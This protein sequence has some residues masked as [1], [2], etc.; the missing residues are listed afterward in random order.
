MYNASIGSA[1]P[2]AP[3]IRMG[4]VDALAQKAFP[5]ALKKGIG[6][7]P[8]FLG[9]SAAG[10]VENVGG[11]VADRVWA[12]AHNA[13]VTN[14]G[15]L[16]HADPATLHAISN[17]AEAW[18]KRTAAYQMK[19]QGLSGAGMMTVVDPLKAGTRVFEKPSLLGGTVLGGTGK[20]VTDFLHAVGG[21]PQTAVW[22]SNIGRVG[23][24]GGPAMTDLTSTIRNMSGDPGRSGAFRNATK[25]A[26]FTNASPWG[27]IYLQST[28]R[29]LGIKKG[30]WP[31]VIMKLGSGV[32]I[33]AAMVT[34]Y[35]ADLG[36]EYLKHQLF[37]RSTDNILRNV[38]I[39]KK[40]KLPTEGHEIAFFDPLTQLV[41]V[42]AEA[43]TASHLGLWT[44]DYWKG[45]NA[46]M[47]N[48]YSEM[49]KQR[50][51]DFN[52][53]GDG[54][55]GTWI[56]QSAMP[57]LPPAI[58]APLAVAGIQMRSPVDMHIAPENR[59][60]GYMAG[61]RGDPMEQNI[62]GGVLPGYTG[63]VASAIGAT[64]GR[65]LHDVVVQILGD[66]DPMQA[67][68][69]NTVY[70]PGQA[71]DR[72]VDTIGQKWADNAPGAGAMFHTFRSITPSQTAQSQ[73]VKLKM[74]GV[75]AI[76]KAVSATEDK[77]FGDKDLLG[78]RKSGYESY[79][80][81]HPAWA[82]DDNTRMLGE[83]IARFKK[84]LAP[85]EQE[86]GVAYQQRASLMQSN[87]YTP[88]QKRDQLEQQTYR[89]INLHE[90][91]SQDIM[92]QEQV[93]SQRYGVEVQFDKIKP[94]Q[95]ML[96][97]KPRINMP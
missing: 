90:R 14:K 61:N 52:P 85:T 32:M 75:D 92:R 25:A 83:D 16:S 11:V 40:G 54:M 31:G 77:K 78:S 3:G 27:N 58:A 66:V 87:K 19:Q 45:E 17:F 30:D 82:P 57:V 65:F 13:L 84:G 29:V 12:A 60:V 47:A 63:D 28:G 51:T 48:A 86:I 68:R 34:L 74:D 69:G 95:P 23:T 46:A 96:G 91:I 71:L 6:F 10:A 80:G 88:Y 67:Q 15:L 79:A 7:D 50:Y 9:Q 49:F 36:E 24:P 94:G 89:I 59:R 64:F 97:F 55:F 70:S 21:G 73:F 72:A 18:Y 38:Y 93:M 33:P 41:K 26:E 35:N 39:G 8:T 4:M 20:I 53:I 81:A 62:L 37:G 76:A 2:R 43:I 56:K 1:L 5:N 44:G 42:A 22:H